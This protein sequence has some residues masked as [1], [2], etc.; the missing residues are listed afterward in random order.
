[1]NPAALSKPNPAA[2]STLP[3]V[4]AIAAFATFAPACSSPPGP[5]EAP[6]APAPPS[7]LDPGTTALNAPDGSPLATAPSPPATKAAPALPPTTKPAAPGAFALVELFTSEGCSSCPPADQALDDLAADAERRALPVYAL[8][9]HVDYWNSLGWV[10]PFSTSAYTSRQEAYA[11]RA[12]SRGLYTPQML[13][14]G[15]EGFIGSDRARARHEVDQALGTAPPSPKRLALRV[16][17]ARPSV[18][19]D[20]DAPELTPGTY[21]NVAL[22]ERMRTQH[23]ARGENGGRT[24]RHRNVV[25]AFEALR[26]RGPGT[27]HVELPAAGLDPA[28]LVVVAYAQDPAT[29]AVLG[30]EAAPVSLAPR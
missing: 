27:F 7:S 3:A 20:V 16:E 24:L 19:V 9:F 4:V 18:R 11:G 14:N 30:A 12:G 17:L 21:L 23:V 6:G 28:S 5:P 22:A 26:S 29:L 1:M 25:R 8:S 10:D 13:V 15:G 2:L